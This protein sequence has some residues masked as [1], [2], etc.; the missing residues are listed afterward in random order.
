MDD[1]SCGYLLGAG[2]ASFATMLLRS[3]VMS[4]PIRYLPCLC[5]K[6]PQT[7]VQLKVAL[8]RHEEWEPSFSVPSEPSFALSPSLAL[9]NKAER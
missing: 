6:H 1:G 2:W 9:P 8:H 3:H 7:F 5:P 4:V